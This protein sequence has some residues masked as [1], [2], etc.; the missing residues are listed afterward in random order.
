ML[1]YDILLLH[2]RVVPIHEH[3]EHGGNGSVP[4]DGRGGSLD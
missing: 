1:K 2:G 3:P 4:A